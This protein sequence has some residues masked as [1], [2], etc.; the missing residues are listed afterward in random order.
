M[1]IVFI[2]R[3]RCVLYVEKAVLRLG[4]KKCWLSGALQHDCPLKKKKVLG[5]VIK[6]VI[7]G[8]VLIYRNCILPFWQ[9]CT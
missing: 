3:P 6:L 7:E 9:W 4:G 1:L 8:L 2:K 5:S